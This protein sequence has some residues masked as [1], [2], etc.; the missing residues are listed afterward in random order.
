MRKHAWRQL[1][2]AQSV[3]LLAVA[4][5]LGSCGSTAPTPSAAPSVPVTVPP[6]AVATSSSSPTPTAS[7]AA[8]TPAPTATAT[9][10]WIA[11]GS[12]AL[13]RGFPQAVLLGNGR[14]LVVGNP[15][16]GVVRP[17]SVRSEIWDPASETWTAGPSLNKP[18]DEFVAVP[19]ADGRVFLTGGVSAGVISEG[20]SQDQHQSFSSSFIANPAGGSSA[21]SGVA[22]QDHARTAPT[23]AALLDGRVLVAG[24]YYLSGAIGLGGPGIAA[25]LAA[26]RLD[27][28]G[29]SKGL[30]GGDVAPPTLV[31]ALATAELYDPASNTWTTTGPLHYARVG[32]AAVTLADGRVL[33]V[34]SAQASAFTWNYREPELNERAYDT[35]ETYDQRSGRFSLT[36]DLPALDWSALATFGPYSIYPE[37]VTSVGTL[38]ALA[39]GGALL[40]GRVTSWTIQA[41][42]LSGRTAVTLR[43]DPTTEHW[44]QVDQTVEATTSVGD[45]EQTTEV[46][47]GHSRD[48]A[49]A[50]R[51]RDGRVLVAGGQGVGVSAAAELYDPATGSWSTLP[52]LPQPRMDG[53]AILLSDG[54]ALLVGG[55]GESAA[56]QGCTGI[57]SAVRFIPGP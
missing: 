44:T 19:L 4:L 14:V 43:F 16:Q 23:A 56:C 31:P 54:S 11:A 3:G 13:G 41:L 50:V 36:G 28:A 40:V 51:L 8:T 53:A 1:I 10:H 35:A 48:G 45:T 42:G 27:P 5:V 2:R 47:A 12:M 18:R 24:G 39:D 57:A 37:G 52:A 9:G 38:V 29:P 17:D 21:W 33:V 7:S 34:G 15:D 22:L 6:T 26:D 46:V 25:I 55:Q 49:L 30:P 20:G 32:A